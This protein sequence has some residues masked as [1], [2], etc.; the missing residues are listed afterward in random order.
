MAFSAEVVEQAWKRSDKSC[1]CVRPDHGHWARCHKA[2]VKWN[3]GKEVWG[4]WETHHIGSPDDDSL[5]NCEILCRCAIKRLL[6]LPLFLLLVRL[7][8]FFV[9]RNPPH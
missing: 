9:Q 4:C 2:L 6:D 3:R 5:A 8:K 1:E 7:V